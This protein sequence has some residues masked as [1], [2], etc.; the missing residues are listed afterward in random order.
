MYIPWKGGETGMKKTLSSSALAKE[1][2][3]WER[4]KQGATAPGT[5]CRK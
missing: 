5:A 1:A 4:I 3:L 2:A